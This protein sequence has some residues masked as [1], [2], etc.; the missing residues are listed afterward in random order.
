MKRILGTIVVLTLTG[1]T[2]GK[3]RS[4]VGSLTV[5]DLIPATMSG[6]VNQDS[7]PFL[8]VNPNR[9]EQMSASAFTTNPAA[10][11]DTAPIFVTRDS[12]AT[13]T[14]NSIL[15]SDNETAD[16]S[17]A[18]DA[19][20]KSLFASILSLPFAQTTTLKD[21][22]TPDVTAPAIMKLLST[23]ANVDQPWVQTIGVSSGTVVYVGLN[24]FDAPGGRTATV[25]V[26]K[27]GM[28]Y[29]SFRIE[30]RATAG[31]DGPSVRPAVAK[32]GTTYAAF[33]SWKQF[34]GN[35]ATAN[36]VVVR[37][38]HG[39]TGTSNFDSLVDPSDNLPGRIVQAGVTIPW[40][41]AQALGQ[42]RIGSTLSLTVDPNNSKR[43]YIA[44]GDRVGNGDIYTIHVRSSSDGGTTW[45]GDL[46][47][48]RDA[49]NVALA[50]SDT[51]GSDGTVAMLYQQLVGGKW[52]TRL[53]QT[54]DD[55]HSRKEDVLA[56][57]SAA[58]PLVQFEPYLGD[59]IYLVGTSN[60]FRGVFSASNRPDLADFPSGVTYQRQ[61]D[62]TAHVL[63]NGGR[64]VAI[65]IDPFYV[66]APILR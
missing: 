13:W 7:E 8:G 1:V 65:S 29:K 19:G 66:S 38:D 27:D 25:D 46:L 20:G 2:S 48:L 9:P 32:D 4:T 40:V 17:H 34:V 35:V 61:A 42:Q 56:Q 64:S 44:W 33:L 39:G 16:I 37:D 10:A 15:P 43:L 36:V 22:S 14:L 11:P 45:S 62:F 52:V 6:E 50:I 49:V 12:G 60:Q 28:N 47:T 41:N 31:Q 57:A 59:Y 3:A 24:D 63:T 18:F 58:E 21:L 54:R 51:A 55:F 23:R 26:S 53:A 5:V 30:S